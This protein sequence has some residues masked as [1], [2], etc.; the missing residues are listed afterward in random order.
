M[1]AGQ[2]LTTPV[3]VMELLYSTRDATEFA[4]WERWLGS[5]REAALDRSTAQSA[6]AAMRELSTRRGLGHRVPI[7]DALIAA[8]AAQRG[9]GVLHHDRHFDVLAEVLAFES[10]WLPPRA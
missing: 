1:R 4:S 5:L 6:I 10:V 7:T 9:A 3:V 8:A 2:I